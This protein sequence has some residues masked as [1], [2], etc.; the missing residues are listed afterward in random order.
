MLP[1][2]DDPNG[3]TRVRAAELL[4]DVEPDKARAALE[5]A[6]GDPN[7]VVRADVARVVESAGLISTDT[8]LRLTLP[9]LR[10]LLRDR[11]PVVRTHAA[12]AILRVTHSR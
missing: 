5:T 12:G 4:A 6:L 9:M 7:P 11:D 10:R 2:L 3:L 8:N 1:L